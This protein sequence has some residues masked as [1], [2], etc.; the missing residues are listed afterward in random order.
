MLKN[1]IDLLSSQD[2]RIGD[3]DIDFAKGGD[4][5]PESIKEVKELI[6]RRNGRRK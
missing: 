4:K 6:K 3:P 1:I 2:Y 5:F